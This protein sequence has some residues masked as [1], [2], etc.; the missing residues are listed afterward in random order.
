MDMIDEADK[1]AAAMTSNFDEITKINLGNKQLILSMR[2]SFDRYYTLAKSVSAGMVEGTLLIEQMQS[3][4][5]EMR[6]ALGQFQTL[7]SGFRDSS[8]T[9]FT[10]RIEQADKAAQEAL[11][12]GMSIGAVVLLSLIAATLLITSLIS[13]DIARVV[14]SLKEM[15]ASGD[16]TRRLKSRGRD[17]I[18]DLLVWFNGFVEQLHNIIAELQEASA[19]MASASDQVTGVADNT[20]R[21][22]ARQQSETDQVATAMNELAATE[23][24]MCTHA[25]NAANAARE[26]SQEAE[27]GRKAVA[28]TVSDIEVLAAK[29]NSASEVIQRLETDAQ[30]IGS[31]LDVILS[32]AEQTNL[33]A[34]NAAIE[35]ARA[36]EHGRGFAVVA[37][38]V[39]T[40][41]NRTQASTQEIRD[42]I[43]RLQ[44][45]VR[46]GAGVMNAS[47]EEARKL[48][49]QA[50]R[51]GE[52][53]LTITQAVGS[54]AQMSQH[55]ASASEEQSHVTQ[56]ID[57]NLMAIRDIT[58]KTAEGAKQTYASS[59]ELARVAGQL[60]GLVK[61][62]RV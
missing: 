4:A 6:E 36:G 3:K 8:Y 17:E 27:A 24:E 40:L 60:Q 25:N 52:S 30:G 9:A 18:G 55:I 20:S 32:I 35:A 19:R 46:N 54:I 62:F 26:A 31:V 15:A 10:L 28:K 42:M 23:Q 49:T 59:H 57:A 53:L 56:S 44:S 50:A 1:L 48:V 41:A 34:L 47:C 7:L 61:R 16:L 38:E 14:E 58:T 39:R 13:G 5:G 45:G 12:L 22:V 2:Q 51:A 33:L 21:Q 43:E 11:V 29:V 37:D